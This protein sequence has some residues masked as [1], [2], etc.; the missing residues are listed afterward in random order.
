MPLTRNLLEMIHY[1]G[2]HHVFEM[3]RLS[4]IG[5]HSDENIQPLL[6]DNTH[7]LSEK[8]I[9]S[10]RM[11][12]RLEDEFLKPNCSTEDVILNSFRNPERL[13]K[14]LNQNNVEDLPLCSLFDDAKMHGYATLFQ[15]NMCPDTS[16]LQWMLS[17]FGTG[18]LRRRGSDSVFGDMFCDYDTFS[19]QRGQYS[20]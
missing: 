8:I 10:G 1:S 19:L 13:L 5:G 16:Y 11:A 3:F 20:W 17:M 4:N 9:G 18:E 12:S 14:Q 7:S 6:F 2:K 15:N